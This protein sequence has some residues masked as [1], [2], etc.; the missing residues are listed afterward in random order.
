MFGAI[1]E[2]EQKEIP[3]KC[4]PNVQRA[5]SKPM[6]GGYSEYDG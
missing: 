3:K 5:C 6:K 4:A 1:L 2:A